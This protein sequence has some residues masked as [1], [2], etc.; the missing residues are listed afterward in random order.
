MDRMNPVEWLILLAVALMNLT[1]V[2]ALIQS[3]RS[4]SVPVDRPEAAA[5]VIPAQAARPGRPRRE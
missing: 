5:P 4:A 2:R 1:A 3:R